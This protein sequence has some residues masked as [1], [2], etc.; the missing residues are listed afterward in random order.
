MDS[1][2]KAL[3]EATAS[4]C[5]ILTPDG[6]VLQANEA[7]I[8]RL[9]VPL[10]DLQGRDF[11]GLFPEEVAQRR[12]AWLAAVLASGSPLEV[13]DE[14]A[15]GAAF[16]AVILPV[17]DAQGAVRQVVAGIKDISESK[18]AEEQRYRLA[19]AIEQALEAIVLLDNDFRVQYLNQSFE[20]LTGYTLRE[21]KERDFG[22]LFQSE[23]EQRQL[24]EVRETLE[25]GDA[26]S[27][28]ARSTRKNGQTFECEQ[29]LYR[30]RY[31]R[32]KELGFV[33]VWRDVTEL[34]ILERQL[35][36][37]QKMEAVGTLAGGL[38]HDFNNI[39]GPIILHTELCL[40]GLKPDEPIHASLSEILEAANRARRLVEQMLGLSRRREEDHPIPFQLSSIVK[41]C[42]KLLGPSLSPQIT[43]TFSK[44]T[45]SDLVLAD[46]AQL[47][48]LVMNLCTNAAQAMRNGGG[49]LRLQIREQVIRHVGKHVA[50]QPGEYVALEVS[51]TGCGIPMEHLERIF[52]PFFTTHGEE[53]GTGLGLAVVLNILSGLGGAIDVESTPG[54]GSR[55]TVLLPRCTLECCPIQPLQ[56]GKASRTSLRVLLVENNPHQ[57]HGERRVLEELGCRVRLSHNAY[58]A[59]A[60]F[61]QNPE[62]FDLVITEMYLPEMDGLELCKEIGLNRPELPVALCSASARSPLRELRAACGAR[63]LLTK[64]FHQQ[65]IAAQLQ[66]LCPDADRA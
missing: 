52:D 20:A 18:R 21:L 33:A 9:G 50:L 7:M 10:R 8:Q 16:R 27:G 25:Q 19:S 14:T 43:I 37:A 39:L 53:S 5:V 59:L 13:E 64:P 56:G 60:L 3:L 6:S 28:K 44:G 47:H 22:D 54:Q 34:T 40:Q 32:S 4:P 41:E 42:L 46:P 23:E 61:R 58:E 51:D 17:C 2:H 36:L 66:Q 65:E 12:R 57:A 35:R 38:A 26:W 29:S 45:T 30:I 31:K 11:F 48:Q 49:E 24:R 15:G 62:D 55:F 63:A 1:L